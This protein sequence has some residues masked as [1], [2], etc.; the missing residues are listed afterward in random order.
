MSDTSLKIQV[1]LDIDFTITDIRIESVVTEQ[2]SAFVYDFFKSKLESEEKAKVITRQLISDLFKE[3]MLCLRPKMIDLVKQIQS[4]VD[5]GHI[6]GVTLFTTAQLPPETY[7]LHELKLNMQDMLLEKLKEL[8]PRVPFELRRSPGR[9]MLKDVNEI[10]AS[11][12]IAFDDVGKSVYTEEK[13]KV[14]EMCLVEQWAL[15]RTEKDLISFWEHVKSNGKLIEKGWNN[16]NDTKVL[17]KVKEQLGEFW[18]RLFDEHFQ[19]SDSE[20]E[21]LGP[22]LDRFVKK[23][24]KE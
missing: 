11:H 23:Y 19:P 17:K 6:A 24:Y 22:I 5:S 12:I 21:A 16:E 7:T 13:D 2:F 20:Q 15:C 9:G 8:F 3:K 4:L 14:F 1:I 18:I 10:K